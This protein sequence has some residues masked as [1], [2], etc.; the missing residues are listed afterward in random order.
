MRT[1]NDPTV[2]GQSGAPGD[3]SK[4]VRVLT[5][6]IALMIALLSAVIGGGVATAA[7][8]AYGK[9]G[10][11]GRQGVTGRVGP[12]GPVGPRGPQGETGPQGDQ[13]PSGP[14]GSNG[15]AVITSWPS[16][17]VPA[18]SPCPPGTRVWQTIYAAA[19]DVIGPYG[20][21]DAEVALNI[22]TN[23]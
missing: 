11:A 6:R 17:V 1:S 4:T 19:N 12:Q 21:H 5:W 20:N 14:K 3:A 15:D 9:T 2:T 7:T 13:G 23:Y 10:P 8:L 22:C 18:D 16:M